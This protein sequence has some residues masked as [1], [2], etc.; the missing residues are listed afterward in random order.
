MEF[1]T[2]PYK[3]LLEEYRRLESDNFNEAYRIFKN[4]VYWSDFY[5]EQLAIAKK[6]L[7]EAEFNFKQTKARKSNELSPTKVSDGE[8]LA[9]FSEEVIRASQEFSKAVYFERTLEN[10]TSTI[11]KIYFDSKNVWDKG[12][13]SYRG[14][15]R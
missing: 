8:R 12:N 7:A 14:K 11:D 13:L 9:L 3:E 15:E 6:L 1:S 10:I 5:G 4:A 2:A